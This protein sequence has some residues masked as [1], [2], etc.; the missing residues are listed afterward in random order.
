MNSVDILRQN[1]AIRAITEACAHI[2]ISRREALLKLQ[3]TLSK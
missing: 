2:A 1:C 3:I